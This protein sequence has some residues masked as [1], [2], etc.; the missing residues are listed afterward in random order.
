[1]T[2]FRHFNLYLKGIKR[3]KKFF[4]AFWFLPRKWLL[5]SESHSLT[6]DSLHFD[7]QTMDAFS[8][9]CVAGL[10]LDED[11]TGVDTED[12][13]QTLKDSTV[14]MVLEKGQKWTPQQVLIPHFHILTH[15]P[16]QHDFIKKLSWSSLRK[17]IYVKQSSCHVMF[18]NTIFFIII[19]I[20]NWA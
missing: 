16:Q 15:K 13:F 17:R 6:R 9:S 10:V 1:M 18:N 2:V 19:E 3:Y 12:F 11:G 20:W 8:V 4:E 7:P 14:L 5:N